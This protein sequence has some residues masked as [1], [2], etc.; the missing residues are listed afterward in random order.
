M[1][2]FCQLFVF[3][4]KE[5]FFIVLITPGE[6][7]RMDLP[8]CSTVNTQKMIGTSEKCLENWFI[9]NF[10]F[11]NSCQFIFWFINS[12]YFWKSIFIF[13]RSWLS[14]CGYYTMILI[15]WGVCG[16]IDPLTGYVSSKHLR[17]HYY[18]STVS[19]HQN[20]YVWDECGLEAVIYN[21]PNQ[22]GKSEVFK[23]H[24]KAPCSCY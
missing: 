13:W 3:L 1:S 21:F 15:K 18:V 2:I 9:F 19:R 7:W 12:F 6:S 20:I 14:F 16:R 23:L 8:K 11:Y 17:W 22:A 10:L 4:S 5:M 24:I